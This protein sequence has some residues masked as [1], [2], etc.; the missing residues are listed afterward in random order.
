MKLLL[1]I[2]LVTSS[3][4]VLSAASKV[5]F[6]SPKEGEVLTQSFKVEFG[7]EGMSVEKA[8]SL[9]SGTGH[10]HLI[11]DGKPIAKGQVIPKNETHK[12]FGDGQTSTELKLTP[13]KHTL[14]LQFADGIHKSYGEEYSKTIEVEV[15]SSIQ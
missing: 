7:V 10:H 14:T 11:I 8:G 3:N 2:A 6:V 1:T 13:G 4:Y 5:H 15:K 12:H 9:K